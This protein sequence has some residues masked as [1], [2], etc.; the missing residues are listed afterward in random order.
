ML[1]DF[2]CIVAADKHPVVVPVSLS[3]M[4]APAHLGVP[5]KNGYK[6]TCVCV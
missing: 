5:G 1:A 3:F 4:T 6:T 2:C